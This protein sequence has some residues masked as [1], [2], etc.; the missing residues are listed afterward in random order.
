MAD[1]EVGHPIPSVDI[2]VKA[3]KLPPD[4][5]RKIFERP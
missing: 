1:D 3:K 5:E 2:S 4:F